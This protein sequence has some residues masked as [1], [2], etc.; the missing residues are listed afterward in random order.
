MNALLGRTLYFDFITNTAMGVVSDAD[1]LPTV[2]VFEEDTDTTVY[3]LTAVKRTAKTGNY[4]VPVECTAVNGFELGKSYNVVASATVG[5]TASKAVIGRFV[6][7]NIIMKRGAIVADGGNTDTTF[8]TDLTEATNDYHK[9]A[10]ILF[11]S[12]S[13]INQVKKI[14]SYTG[15]T[16]FVTAASAFTVAPSA[17]DTFILLVF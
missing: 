14:L 17:A 15:A 4:R 8:K 16:K 2:E 6:I 1:G 3:A 13:L 11:T 12:G 10:L 5:G 9:D 7:E